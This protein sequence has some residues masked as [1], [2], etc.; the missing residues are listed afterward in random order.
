MFI[1]QCIRT[2]GSVLEINSINPNS[3]ACFGIVSRHGIFKQMLKYKLE[4][5]I[6]CHIPL[7]ANI[8]V[9]FISGVLFNALSPIAMKCVLFRHFWLYL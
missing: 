9:K 1:L 8:K 5:L 2:Q 6:S 3:N 7:E 4:I